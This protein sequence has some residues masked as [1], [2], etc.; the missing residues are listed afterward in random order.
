[1]LV[2]DES[3]EMEVLVLDESIEMSDARRRRID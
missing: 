1:M 2:L 3:I